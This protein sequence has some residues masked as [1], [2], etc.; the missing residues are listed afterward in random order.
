[1]KTSLLS[2]LLASVSS[3][4]FAKNI[5]LE[6]DNHKKLADFAE[7]TLISSEVRMISCQ[8]SISQKRCTGYSREEENKKQY[9]AI[10]TLGEGKDTVFTDSLVNLAMV[11]MDDSYNLL[12][13]YLFHRGPSVL[14]HLATLSPAKIVAHCHAIYHDLSRKEI[15][16]YRRFTISGVRDFKV[17]DN[18]YDQEEA[19]ITLRSIISDIK[20]GKLELDEI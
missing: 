10:T 8:S 14:A 15:R 2:V 16:G 13:Y 9:L 1:M 6:L 7:R 5:P 17:E 4:A 3:I 19:E 12:R 20:S 11:R 18:C